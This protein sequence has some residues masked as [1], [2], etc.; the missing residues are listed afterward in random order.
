MY[1]AGHR[2]D[3][4]REIIVI[5]GGIAGPA[6][7]LFLKRGGSRVRVL[8]AHPQLE[9]VG[10]GFQVAPNGMRVLAALGIAEAVGRLGHV[11]EG[12]TFYN[13]R[14]R[15]LTRVRVP[16]RPVMLSRAG[17]HEVLLQAAEQEGVKVEY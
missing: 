5:G 13:S 6:L 11:G 10:G 14:G 7:G 12:F 15:L 1:C 8:E 2:G 17:L 3:M 9:A 16:G 4:K